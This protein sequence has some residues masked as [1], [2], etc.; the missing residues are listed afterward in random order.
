[1]TNLILVPQARLS[2]AP[3]G[4]ASVQIT[5]ATNFA[6]YVLECADRLPTAGWSIVT[7]AASTI[8]NRLTVT[9]DTGDLQRFYRLRKP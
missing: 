9:M 5:W 3:A 2:I 6:D 7:N 4:T 1:M 8:G